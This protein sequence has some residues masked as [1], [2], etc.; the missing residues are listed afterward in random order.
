MGQFAVAALYERRNLLIQKPALIE[1]RYKK[2]K[3]THCRDLLKR[4][5]EARGPIALGGTQEKM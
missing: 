3:V 4:A 2:A 5:Q 1:R